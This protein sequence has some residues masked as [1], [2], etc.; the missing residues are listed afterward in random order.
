MKLSPRYT[1]LAIICSSAMALLAPIYRIVMSYHEDSENLNIRELSTIAF[2]TNL[3]RFIVIVSLTSTW[4]MSLLILMY[5][6]Y[7]ELLFR[8]TEFKGKCF[9]S[10]MSLRKAKKYKIPYFRLHN[11]KN[12][13]MWLSIRSMIK[14]L[15]LFIFLFILFFFIFI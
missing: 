13:Q 1:M 9:D 8:I 5:Y 11:V 14:V 2:G 10:I 3:K 15:L 12:I 4:V 6:T 7:V